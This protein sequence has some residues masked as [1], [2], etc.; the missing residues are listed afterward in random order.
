MGLVRLARPIRSQ[1][2]AHEPHSP[3]LSLSLFETRQ[4]LAA[5]KGGLL[6]PHYIGTCA[7][8]TGNSWHTLADNS[9]GTH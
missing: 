7:I 2:G 6:A 3:P 9:S 8:R 4:R 5:E 1:V